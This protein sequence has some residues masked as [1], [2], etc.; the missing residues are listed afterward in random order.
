[1]D[2][3][4][5]YYVFL[6]LWVPLLWPALALRGWK[7][8]TMFLVV[9]VGAFATANEVWQSF[10]A[11]NAI[12]LDIVLFV[13]MLGFLYAA[14]AAVLWLARWRAGA[15]LLAVFL[16]LTGGFLGYRWTAAVQEAERVRATVEERDAL[17]FRA[18]FRDRATFE[19]FFGPFGDTGGLYPAGHWQ[20]PETA[21]FSRLVVNADGRAWLFYR[22]GA[23]ECAYR[24]G[25]RP[26]QRVV[27]ARGFEWQGL[28]RPVAGN[29]LAVRIVQPDAEHLTLEARGQ[30]VALAKAPPPVGEKAAPDALAYLGPYSASVCDG[31]Q[32]AV[33]QLWLWR[34]GDRLFATGVFRTLPAGR[35][36]QF[37]TPSAMGEGRRA[38]GA[39]SFAWARD[40]EPWSASVTPGPDDVALRLTPPGRDAET[41]TLA[42]GAIFG[43]ETIA[44]APR[45]SAEEWQRWFTTVWVGRFFSGEIPACPR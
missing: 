3:L 33:R 17:V 30:A 11:P 13:T 16:M 22:C 39:W 24:P 36:A 9:L 12:R 31:E 20:G 45:Q 19:D 14:A 21:A 29:L 23:T 8:G 44:L 4:L 43:D 27:G 32:A 18:M 28:L 35:R 42:P 34:D 6:A 41:L 7:R 5:V 25:T 10:G 37:V 2:A 40:G 15:I 1:M 26:L 38:G